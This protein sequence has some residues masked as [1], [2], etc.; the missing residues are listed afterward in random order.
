MI[1]D[2]PSNNVEPGLIPMEL[3]INE[4]D[5]SN[6]HH[7]KIFKVNFKNLTIDELK[8]SKADYFVV[9]TESNCLLLEPS[10][11]SL[12]MSKRFLKGPT[13]IED[14]DDLFEIFFQ[15]KDVHK[16]YF[17]IYHPTTRYRKEIYSERIKLFRKFFVENAFYFEPQV[18]FIE[19]TNK[20]LAYRL[21]LDFNGVVLHLTNDFGDSTV[22][23]EKK[24][25]F[26]IP[27]AWTHHNAFSDSGSELT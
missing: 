23:S 7:K 18:E 17:L 22:A 4:F 3:H 24:K 26:N 25:Y 12:E 27:M 15:N 8:Q 13:S 2:L 5:S 21:G 19:I 14:D 16:H 9:D 6:E 10:E 11:A 1:L 20:L